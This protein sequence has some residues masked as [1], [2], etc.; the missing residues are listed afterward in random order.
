MNG[1]STD[2]DTS[3]HNLWRKVA[4]TKREKKKENRQA[5]AKQKPVNSNS[6]SRVAST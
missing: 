5:K 6:S 2:Y 1:T 4:E 3:G